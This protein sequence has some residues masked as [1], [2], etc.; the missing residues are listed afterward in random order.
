MI[1][2]DHIGDELRAAVAAASR[3]PITAYIAW[4]EVQYDGTEV[5]GS[6]VARITNAEVSL[7]PPVD[8][9]RV[10]QVQV[11]H[12]YISNRSSVAVD[13]S[14]WVQRA[15]DNTRYEIY[16]K[17]D[18]ADREIFAYSGGGRLERRE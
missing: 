13:L 12:M 4:N 10:R 2:L 9:D 18:L 8:L 16:N 11:T 14:V 5:K 7:V 15:G 6:S 17:A 3:G 1:I